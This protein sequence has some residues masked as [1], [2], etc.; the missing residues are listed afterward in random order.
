MNEEVDTDQ[1]LERVIWYHKLSSFRAKAAPKVT[2]PPWH[3]VVV[4]CV[5]GDCEKSVP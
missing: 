4:V 3:V 5:F 1:R 2:F